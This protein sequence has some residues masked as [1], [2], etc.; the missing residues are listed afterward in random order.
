MKQI[1]AKGISGSVSTGNL[2]QAVANRSGDKTTGFKAKAVQGAVGLLGDEAL[3]TALVNKIGAGRNIRYKRK[4][5]RT[6]RRKKTRK[7]HNKKTR[8]KSSRRR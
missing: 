4:R 7:K 3:N 8:K 5:K 2:A 6:K 1:I